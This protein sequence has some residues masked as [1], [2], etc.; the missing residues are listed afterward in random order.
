ALNA[1]VVGMASTV[2][3]RGYWL[4]TADGGV[5]SYGNAPFLGSAGALALQS[6]V[7]GM[8]ADPD[9]HGYW[10]AAADGGVFAYEARYRGNGAEGLGGRAVAG[11]AADRASGG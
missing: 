1:P 3:G 9:G 11:I 7:I 2:D 5:F 4:V 8:A 10:L 6:P